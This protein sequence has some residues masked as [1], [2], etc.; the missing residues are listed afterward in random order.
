MQNTYRAGR[1]F[2]E[3]GQQASGTKFN[4]QALH[5]RTE[6][7]TTSCPLISM[8]PKLDTQSINQLKVS[9]KKFVPMLHWGMLSS[10]TS[11]LWKT[12]FPSPL[13]L[14]RDADEFISPS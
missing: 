7:S 8:S 12:L 3:E 13:P 11:G 2:C 10:Y 5:S 4:P 9:I 1:L 6:W 14:K